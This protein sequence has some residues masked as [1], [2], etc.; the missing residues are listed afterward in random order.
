MNAYFIRSNGNETNPEW[1]KVPCSIFSA[2]N[3][4]LDVYIKSPT[5]LKF[6]LNDGKIHSSLALEH[7]RIDNCNFLL[8]VGR[9]PLFANII[10]NQLSVSGTVFTLEQRNKWSTY[11]WRDAFTFYLE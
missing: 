11:G 2:P 9:E 3:N 10:K 1:V 7:F 5:E 6:V 4:S 8:N